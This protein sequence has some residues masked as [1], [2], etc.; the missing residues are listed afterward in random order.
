MSEMGYPA[1]R[2]RPGA[3]NCHTRGEPCL[4][5]SC[6]CSWRSHRSLPRRRHWRRRTASSSQEFQFRGPGR[7]RRVRRAPEHRRPRPSTS[8]AGGCRAAP[9]RA[10]PRRTAPPSRRASRS[11]RG[12]TTCSATRPAPTPRS[13]TR[14]TPR[15]RDDGGAQIVLASGAKEDGVANQDES[16]DVCR[17]GTGLAPRPRTATTRSSARTRAGRT[18]TRT[19]R[20]SR[21]EGRN[22]AVRLAAG[23][24]ARDAVRDLGDPGH[25]APLKPCRRA[26]THDRDRHRRALV[27]LLRPGSDSRRG[28]GD[29]RRHPRFRPHGTGRR[30][31]DRSR[32]GRGVPPGGAA[33]NLTTTELASP[34]LTVTVD[35]TGNTLP[36]TTVVGVDRLPPLDV[37]EDDASGDV[38]TG[39]VL[40]DPSEDGLDFWESLEGMLIAVSDAEVV[41]PTNDFG[42]IPVSVGGLAEPARRGAV[43]LRPD[44]TNPERILLDD[45]LAP[46]RPR[47]SATRSRPIRP[48]SST[49]RLRTSSCSSRRPPWSSPAGWPARRPRRRGRELAVATFNVENLDP[50]D[51]VA[52]YCGSPTSSSTTSRRPISSRSRRCRTTTARPTPRSRIHPSRLPPSPRPFR[53]PAGRSTTGGRSIPSTTRT[54]ASRVGTSASRSCSGPT[55]ASSS[56][57][58]RAERRR[59]RRRC[60]GVEGRRGFRPARAGS[61]LRTPPSRTAASRWREFRYRGETL[62]VVANHF[63]SKGAIS[64]SSAGS[65]R[66][67]ARRRCSGTHRRRS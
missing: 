2:R 11:D 46:R 32:D 67:P 25:G 65:S 23:A 18:P 35:S 53:P 34:G 57:T 5:S 28:P 15:H 1:R 40:F 19:S 41:G 54:A 50:G 66:P 30:G 27:E 4:E 61:S 3:L 42:E 12:S 63:N 6:V 47:T 22:P 62:F 49:T 64:L 20:T 10:G 56:S 52:K 26:R 31:G 21:A 37:I 24:A 16:A 8:P 60:W 51:G 45:A 29:L 39:G 59:P 43:I 55:A 9:A 48:A 13:R 58:G 33:E 7:Q 38:E 44:D 17:E 36:A 14:R